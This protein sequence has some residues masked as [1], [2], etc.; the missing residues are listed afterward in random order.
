[1]SHQDGISLR[2]FAEQ[3]GV[4]E[5]C[6]R[7]WVKAGKVMG[8]RKHPLTKKWVIYPPAKLALDS[9]QWRFPALKGGAA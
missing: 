7:R 4:S 3:I 8:A 6:L 9:D 1:M 5:Q 2:R